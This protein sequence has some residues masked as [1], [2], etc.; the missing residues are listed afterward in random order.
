ME[1][2]RMDWIDLIK[3]GTTGVLLWTRWWIFLFDKMLENSWVAEQLEAFQGE[4]SSME[5]HKWL[6]SICI[7]YCIKA[8]EMV[9]NAARFDQHCT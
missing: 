4:L 9:T 6:Q 7:I 8:K 5:L 2:G 1:C 3:I